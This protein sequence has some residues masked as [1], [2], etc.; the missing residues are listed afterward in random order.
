MTS[1]LFFY[2]TTNYSNHATI[3]DSLIA[4]HAQPSRR[5]P[6]TSRASYKTSHQSDISACLSECLAIYSSLITFFYS[7]FSP[8]DLVLSFTQ[9]F[10]LSTV[11]PFVATIL[12]HPP[13][14]PLPLR[15]LR[16]F[17]AENHPFPHFYRGCQVPTRE[18]I[19]RFDTFFCLYSVPSTQ[20]SVLS[21][22]LLAF[23]TPDFAFDG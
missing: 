17:V 3:A 21:F 18:P 9:H 2:R 20:H 11:F 23:P 8:Q 22:A 10:V 15:K 6:T 4:A 7:A 12:P 5:F 1:D 14:R 19:S 13:P 16:L